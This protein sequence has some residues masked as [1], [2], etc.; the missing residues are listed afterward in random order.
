MNLFLGLNWPCILQHIDREELHR[1]KDPPRNPSQTAAAGVAALGQENPGLVLTLGW[2]WPDTGS[3]MISQ[4]CI[5]DSCR[6][7]SYYHCIKQLK[8][9]FPLKSWWIFFSFPITVWGQQM[10][11]KASTGL[12]ASCLEV[13]HSS[14]PHLE[15]SWTQLAKLKLAT[16]P[17]PKGQLFYAWSWSLVGKRKHPDCLGIKVSKALSQ[18]RVEQKNYGKQMHK[19]VR[20]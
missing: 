17:F 8:D 3:E 18:M 13:F 1:P 4:L 10:K 11:P 9:H 12:H 15:P 2:S 20:K 6:G 19:A 14:Q 5:L 16:L 7:F